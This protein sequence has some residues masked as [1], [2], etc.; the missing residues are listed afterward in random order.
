MNLS[1]N[2][3]VTA[4]LIAV[5]LLLQFQIWT[6]RG[7]VQEVSLMKQQLESQRNTNAQLEQ[8]IGRIESEISDLKEGLSTVEEKARYE[9]GMLKQNEIFVQ[10]AR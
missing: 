2:R 8:Q 9:M 1:I 5:L 7:S 6:G 10:I 4:V 3:I